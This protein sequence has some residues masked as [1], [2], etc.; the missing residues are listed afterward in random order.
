M[1]INNNI[2]YENPLAIYEALLLKVLGEIYDARKKTE[3][4][5]WLEYSNLLIDKFAIHSASFFHLSSG[6]VERKTSGEVKK[7]KGYDLFTVNTTIRVLIETYIAF[8]HIFVEPKR[9]SE[10]YFRFLLWKLDGL[11]QEKK[12]EIEVTDFEG[13]EKVI[14]DRD[15]EIANVISKIEESEFINK[16]PDNYLI[17]IFDPTKRKAK[18][19]F[20]IQDDK[21]RVLQITALIKHCCKTRA[22]INTYKHSSLHTHSNFPSVEEFRKVKGKVISKKYTDPLTRLAIYLTCMFIYDICEIDKNAKK[23]L[24]QM[25]EGFRNF[26]IGIT[27]SIRTFT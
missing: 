18:W 1:S 16:I 27:K 19:R 24:N 5:E 4:K 20:L 23:Q 17:K 13:V 12:Y 14:K 11:Y 15:N 26:I 6:V 7:A 25:E 21:I 22:F 10:Q 8:N 3:V 9:E 2:L